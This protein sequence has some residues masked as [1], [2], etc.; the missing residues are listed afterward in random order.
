MSNFEPMEVDCK[1]PIAQGLLYAEVWKISLLI[2][3]LQFYFIWNDGKRC[4]YF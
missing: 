2:I 1:S 4:N 3:F